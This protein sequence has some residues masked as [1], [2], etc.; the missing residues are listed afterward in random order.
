MV[1]L[2]PKSKISYTSKLCLKYVK[3]V[4][5]KVGYI[6]ARDI[7]I[8]VHGKN[9]EKNFHY[10]KYSFYHKKLTL[11]DVLLIIKPWSAKSKETVVGE[12][13]KLKQRYKEKLFERQF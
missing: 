2:D 5:Q 13:M 1:N 6:G 9:V 10:K 11:I 12:F 7:N 3:G 8:D 4:I